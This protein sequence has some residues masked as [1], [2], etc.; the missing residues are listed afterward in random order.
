MDDMNV[1]FVSTISAVQRDATGVL[2]EAK[3]GAMPALLG[4]SAEFIPWPGTPQDEN[5]ILLHH[6]FTGDTIVLGHVA[7]GIESSAA[8]I[9]FTN[10]GSESQASASIYRVLLVESA[11]MVSEERDASPG[12]ELSRDAD[13]LHVMFQDVLAGEATLTITDTMG[14][15]VMTKTI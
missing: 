12:L 10:T 15:T 13:M 7:G 9:F 1:P 11:E 14:R 4:A 3:V 2:T 6:R 8:N 5:G